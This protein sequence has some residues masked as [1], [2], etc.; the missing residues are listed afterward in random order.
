VAGVTHEDGSSDLAES[1]SADGDGGIGK[2][3]V[4]VSSTA[5][6]VIHNL[7][8]LGVTDKDELSLWALLV[9]AVNSG[10]NGVDS[11]DGRVGVADTTTGGLTT[12]GGVVDSLRSGTGVGT[13]YKVDYN[14]GG[15]VSSGSSGFTGTE[16]VD[17]WA[18][19]LFKFCRS[20]RSLESKGD[21]GGREEFLEHF[22]VFVEVLTR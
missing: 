13:Q 12:T 16:N 9:E 7:T 1:S 17:V 5:E 3:L 2:T 6:C 19:T 14:T 8:T 18:G 22:D 11:L 21:K 15:S 4:G 20:S 10:S